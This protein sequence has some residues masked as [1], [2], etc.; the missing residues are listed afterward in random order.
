MKFSRRAFI[1]LSAFITVSATGSILFM[2]QKFFGKNPFGLRLKRILRSPHYKNDSFQNLSPTEVMRKEASYMKMLQN[3]FSRPKDT[4]PSAVIPSVKTDLINLKADSPTIVWFGHSSYFI[5]SKDITVLIDPVFSGAASPVGGF[6]KSFNGTDAY[7]VGEFPAIDM[8]FLSHDHYDHLDY[9][10]ILEFIPKVKKFYV[11]LGV[12]SHLEYWGV[13]PAKIVELD[14]WDKHQ[15]AGDIEIIAAP[16]RH[17][18]GRSLT[19]GKTLWSAFIVNMHGYRLF[20]GGDSGYDTHFK[21]IGDKYGPFD[22]AM[23]E[24]GQYGED[25][26][27]IHM[28][29]EQTAQAA[30]DLNAR[31]L[32]PVHWAKFVLANHPWYEPIE[33]LMPAAQKL[34]LPVTTPMIGEPIV[35]GEKY[36]EKAWWRV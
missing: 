2:R 30:L 3:T 6:V 11:S 7:K 31:L 23:I 13:D 1:A 9:K 25:W 29:P 27:Y 12:G 24:N 22:I 28:F 26:P 10:T 36:P 19:R 32:L 15:V 17:F 18:S 35:L 5:K 16:A 8:M 4:K 21:E 20:L 14:W 33:R 34:N